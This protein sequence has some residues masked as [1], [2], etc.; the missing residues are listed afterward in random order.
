MAVTVS[1]ISVPARLLAAVSSASVS[2][3]RPPLRPDTEHVAVPVVWQT[4]KVGL[5]LVGEAATPTVAVPPLP[6][7]S[8]TVMANC[9]VPPGFTVLLVPRV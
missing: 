6:L 2:I 7:V 9:T 5:T 4:K 8:H 1:V 3:R